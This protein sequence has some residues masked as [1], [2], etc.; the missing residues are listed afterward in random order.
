MKRLKKIANSKEEKYN[1]VINLLMNNDKNGTWN[2]ILSETNNNIDEATNVLISSLERI[3]NEEG[4]EGDEL[5]FYINQ[6]NLAKSI[7]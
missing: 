5:Q 7:N 4:Y 3:V 6:L 1:E 2:E